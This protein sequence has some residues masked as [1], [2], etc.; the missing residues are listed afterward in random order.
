MKTLL[1]ILVLLQVACVG[2]AFGQSNVTP[3]K[4]E[5]RFKYSAVF[6]CL[7]QQPFLQDAIYQTLVSIRNPQ[8]KSVTFTKMAVQT[9]PEGTFV[10]AVGIPKSESLG[11]GQGITLDCDKIL[12][13]LLADASPAWPNGFVVIESPEELDVWVSYSRVTPPIPITPPPT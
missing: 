5:G 6:L 9:P 7:N 4:I 11:L 12:A 8:S 2:Q 1:S 10:G 13:E 3:K